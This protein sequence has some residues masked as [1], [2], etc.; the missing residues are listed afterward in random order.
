[1]AQYG[2]VIERARDERG[3]KDPDAANRLALDL[4][5]TAIS[6]GAEAAS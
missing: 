3:T 2:E 1:M 6:A 4:A 5:L